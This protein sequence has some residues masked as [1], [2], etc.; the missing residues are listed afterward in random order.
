MRRRRAGGK[1]PK[2][3][4]DGS[5]TAAA[6]AP[7]EVEREA[8]HKGGG[9][10][11]EK[12]AAK[13]VSQSPLAEFRKLSE[14]KLPDFGQHVGKLAEVCESRSEAVDV[15]RRHMLVRLCSN[16]GG[17]PRTLELPTIDSVLAPLQ[18]ATTLLL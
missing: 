7:L 18:A 2:A 12:G 3:Q 14:A 4:K 17:P 5:N 8:G 9:G 10:G 16:S 1:A 11:Q 6:T 15:L 13:E